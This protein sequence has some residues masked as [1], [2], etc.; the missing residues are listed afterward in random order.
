ML[1][2]H[3]LTPTIE[4]IYFLTGLLR[5]GETI[6]FRTFPLGPYNIAELIG[7][8]C[9]SGTNNMGTQVPINK[10]L[11]LSLKVIFLLIGRI[12]GSAALD[13]ASRAH[14][15][16]A[17]QCLNAQV[18]EWSTTLLECMKRHLTECHMRRQRNFWFGTILCA[19]FFFEST[20][21]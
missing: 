8:H 15:N 14:M 11:D 4:D 2:E 6:N 5:R 18:F 12:T 7:L 17:V 1:E 20:E 10:I 3:L 9:E 21:P 19:F 16:F 13:Q